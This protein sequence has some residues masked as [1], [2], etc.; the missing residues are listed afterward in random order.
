MSVFVSSFCTD[1]TYIQFSGFFR[2]FLVI[3]RLFAHRAKAVKC[4]C[5]PLVNRPH[6]S[7]QRG[8][9]V[10]AS[11]TRTRTLEPAGLYPRHGI[12]SKITHT[13]THSEPEHKASCRVNKKNRQCVRE[14]EHKQNSAKL[15]F[16][17]HISWLHGTAAASDACS[18]NTMLFIGTLIMICKYD[19]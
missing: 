19:L 10:S 16:A 12:R 2:F 8:H 3:C 13:H 14:R 7:F 1:S 15:L 9:F 18:L 11:E 17:F 6:S 5:S 4:I